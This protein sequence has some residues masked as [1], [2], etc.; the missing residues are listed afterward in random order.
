MSQDVISDAL[1]QIM[2]AKKARKNTVVIKRY[3]NLLIDVLKLAKKHGYI[4][5]YEA[6]GRELEI[7]FSLNN[8]KAIKP[9]FTVAVKVLD[10]Y[11]R[12]YLPARNFGMIII[13]TNKGLM[14]QEEAYEKNIGGSLLAYFY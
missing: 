1:N 7:Q 14:T 4:T 3:S 6:K 12:R 11:V 9:R 13:S 2:N 10:K 5:E 8:C